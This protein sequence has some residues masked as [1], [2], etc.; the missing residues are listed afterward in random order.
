L[1]I[2]KPPSEAKSKLKELIRQVEL[3]GVE[4]VILRQGQECARL[5]P[6]KPAAEPLHLMGFAR[7]VISF[8]PESELQVDNFSL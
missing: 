2:R 1:I 6:T 8:T 5:V 4:T 7:D 3:E